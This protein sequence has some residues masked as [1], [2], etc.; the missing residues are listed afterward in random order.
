M[1]NWKTLGMTTRLRFSLRFLLI[2][3]AALAVGL[4]FWRVGYAQRK[5]REDDVNQIAVGHRP[6]QVRVM[7][8]APHTVDKD[9]KK[10]TWGYAIDG[11]GDETPVSVDFCFENGRVVGIIPFYPPGPEIVRMRRERRAKL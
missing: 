11:S 7:L 1:T 5:V 9:A 6:W 2:A 8:G 10:V 3:V 4:S